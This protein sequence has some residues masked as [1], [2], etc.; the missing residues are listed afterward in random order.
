MA[1]IP[2]NAETGLGSHP[3]LG[4][5][6]PPRDTRGISERPADPPE[7]ASPQEAAQYVNLTPE[8]AGVV[9]RES[10]QAVINRVEAGH[11]LSSEKALCFLFAMEVRDRC[12]PHTQ[13]DF[14]NQCY[15]ELQGESKYLDLLL[16][17]DPQSKVAIEFKLPKK[18][19]YGNTVQTTTR[20]KVYRDLARLSYL[21]KNSL[22]AC[23]C[24]FLMAS[25]E[26]A[27]LNNSSIKK[28]P[29][30]I[31]RQGHTITAGNQLIAEGLPL[32]DVACRFHWTN[33]QRLGEKWSHTGRFAWLEPIQL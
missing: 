26:D 3:E 28:H 17:T 22:Q 9:I 27:Y 1:L 31:T 20:A 12:G 10:W 4:R 13:V 30:F 23:A 24:F 5:R 15:E 32:T 7:R 2:L 14:E 6:P 8:T 11:T 25:D 18:S 21:R 19:Q 16:Y 33:I 29:D